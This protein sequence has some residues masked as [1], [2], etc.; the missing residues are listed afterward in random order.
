MGKKCLG[1]ET[2][3][4]MRTFR[5]CTYPELC[6]RVTADMSSF[7]YWIC[8]DTPSTYRLGFHGNTTCKYR[9]TLTNIGRQS[10]WLV[11]RHYDS[12]G[13]VHYQSQW[14][15]GQYRHR[16]KH[17]KRRP[18]RLNGLQGSLQKYCVGQSSRPRWRECLSPV[19]RTKIFAESLHSL[20][21]R[22][23]AVR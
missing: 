18:W 5:Q 7:W 4:R 10:S 2:G 8:K 14:H 15:L 11:C 3:S 23:R 1:R 19:M 22:K 20:G 17:L 12:I 21:G 6:I 13:P 9:L 16:W